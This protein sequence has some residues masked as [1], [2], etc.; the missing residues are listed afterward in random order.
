MPQKHGNDAL[1]DALRE[2]EWQEFLSSTINRWTGESDFKQQRSKL[3]EKEI[4]DAA[5]R[6]FARNGISKSRIKDIAAEAGIANSAIYDYFTSKE[7]IAYKLPAA[8]FSDFFYEYAERVK[9][10]KS[11]YEKLYTYLWLAVDYARRHPQWARFLYLEIWPSVLIEETNVGRCINDY[12]DVIHYLINE[13]EKNGEWPK[14]ENPYELTAIF[15]G[16]VNQIIITRALYLKPRHIMKA[17]ES[18]LPKLLNLLNPVN[19]G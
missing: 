5:V 12:S 4:Q 10:T 17:A 3:R 8:F 11:S 9:N 14:V 15:I 6:V 1:S 16:S 7:D 18:M 13:G 2:S 19:P